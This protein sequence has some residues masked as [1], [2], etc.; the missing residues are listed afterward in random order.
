MLNNWTEPSRLLLVLILFSD[1]QETAEHV[2]GAQAMGEDEIGML[3]E[4]Y[5]GVRDIEHLRRPLSK[6]HAH[7]GHRNQNVNS[8]HISIKA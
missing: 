7:E 1:M 2:V 6:L 4:E 8:I 5:I 3:H